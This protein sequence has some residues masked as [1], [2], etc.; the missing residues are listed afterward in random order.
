MLFL[1]KDLKLSFL[2]QGKGRNFIDAPCRLVAKAKPQVLTSRG[3]LKT[4][5]YN[6]HI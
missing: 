5:S 1:E 2:K 6:K 4:D 3:S